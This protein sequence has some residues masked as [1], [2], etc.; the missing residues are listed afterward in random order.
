MRKN[1]ELDPLSE[2]VVVHNLVL[3]T[4]ATTL[5][6][7]RNSFAG[8]LD[9]SVIWREGTCYMG[10]SQ[11]STY[12]RPG[13]H[14]NLHHTQTKLHYTLENQNQNQNNLYSTHVVAVNKILLYS[15]VY[16]Y[17]VYRNSI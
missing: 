15:A 1:P 14:P 3:A 13:I 4:A 5:V 9:Q 12:H 10:N 7:N 16:M 2:S 17:V 11:S 6:P 8:H